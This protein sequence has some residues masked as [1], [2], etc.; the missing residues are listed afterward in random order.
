[1]NMPK[2]P[3]LAQPM[4]T[5]RT[6]KRTGSNLEQPAMQKFHAVARRYGQKLANFDANGSDIDV[7]T[8]ETILQLPNPL[9]A[10]NYQN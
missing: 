3:V 5:G 1:M 8:G 6:I 4:G 7:Q 2:L 9:N 10:G